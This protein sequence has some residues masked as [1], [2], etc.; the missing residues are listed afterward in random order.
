ML[1]ADLNLAHVEWVVQ[2]RIQEPADYLFNIGGERGGNAPTNA[3]DLIRDVSEAVMRRVIGDVSVDTYGR[4][5]SHEIRSGC[6]RSKGSG[7]SG[8]ALR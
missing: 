4:P 1:T 7:G 2:Y 6:T 3:R 5:W 8:Q